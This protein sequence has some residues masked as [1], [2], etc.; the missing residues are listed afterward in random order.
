MQAIQSFLS[1]RGLCFNQEKTYIAHVSKGFNFLSWHFRRE[2][3][4]VEVQ[5]TDN[6][7]KRIEHELEDFI[8]QFKGTQRALI[9]KLNDKL[10]GWAAYHRSTDA[11]MV[12]RH[13]DAIVE[14]L[15]VLK[16]CQKYSRW[17]RETVPAE[18]LD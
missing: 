8:M 16:M 3:G 12:F 10:S 2:N 6:A 7:I 18:V 4:V 14:G 9:E 17:H 13:I 11:Y 15:L 5:P 1:E